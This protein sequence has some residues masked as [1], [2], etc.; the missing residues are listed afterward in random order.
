MTDTNNNA[1]Q[2]TEVDPGY[3]YTIQIAPVGFG[4]LTAKD[5]AKS[6]NITTIKFTRTC[7]KYGVKKITQAGSEHNIRPT[8]VFSPDQIRQVAEILGL[9]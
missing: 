3:G 8:F 7:E 1:G 2:I 4:F 9:A 5:A 6:L